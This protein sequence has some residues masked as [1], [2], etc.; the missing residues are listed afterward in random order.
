M[1]KFRPFLRLGLNFTMC[2]VA[3]VRIFF[4]RFCPLIAIFGWIE[5]FG[6]TSAIRGLTANWDRL[7][8]RCK[9]GV[10]IS[11]AASHSESFNS[12]FRWGISKFTTILR[13]RTVLI[14]QTQMPTAC[15]IMSMKPRAFLSR[16]GTCR[17]IN[18]ATVPL[19]LMAMVFNDIYIKNL[20]LQQAYGFA[21][22]IVY[23]EL[24]TPSYME[25]DNNFTDN[26]YLKFHADSTIARDG[27][28]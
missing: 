13:G 17:S 25:I 18:W 15:R 10:C 11:P 2:I 5:P 16:F 9:G 20:A 28:T 6:G 21:Y 26:I 23:T 14:Q 27:C 1:H 8:P 3:P 7:P 22:P 24:T 4:Q 19:H 12:V